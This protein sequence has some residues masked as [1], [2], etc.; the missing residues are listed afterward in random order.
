MI[1]LYTGDGKGKTSAAV[2]MCVRAAGH[3]RQI[4]FAQFMK[5]NDTGEISV[6]KRLPEVT[7]LRS[8][9]SFGFFNS[10]TAK[11]KEELTR[12]HNRILETL[13]ELLKD[14]TDRLIVL[15]EVTYPVKFGLLDPALLSRL[16]SY[17]QRTELV[18]TGRDPA[19]FLVSCADYLTE[20]KCLRHPCQKGVPAREGVEY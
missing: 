2:G 7:V 14:G 4:C 19:D 15:D 11:E 18:L 17:G 12:I 10:L 9:V 8:P 6:L 20:M 16:L 5:G 1:H 3:G 13:L